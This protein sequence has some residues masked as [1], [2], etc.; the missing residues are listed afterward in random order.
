MIEQNAPGFYYVVAYKRHDQNNLTEWVT[1]AVLDPKI[2]YYVVPNQPTF[3]PYELYVKAA[4]SI[5]ESYATA[6]T[7]TGY[8]GEDRKLS[9]A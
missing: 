1:T 6:K 8:S 4:N 5:G 3:Q 7:I 9:T 2:D